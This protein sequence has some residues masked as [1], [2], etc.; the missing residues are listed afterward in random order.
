MFENTSNTL[1]LCT[2]ERRRNWFS[3]KGRKDGRVARE[4]TTIH[5][6]LAS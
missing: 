2:I 3:S 4:I 6:E 5:V 1:Q